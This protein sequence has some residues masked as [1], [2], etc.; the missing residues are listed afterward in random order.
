MLEQKEDPNEV[1]YQLITEDLQLEAF[2][3]IE[4]ELT[5]FVMIE[6]KQRLSGFIQ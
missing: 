6:V 1:M 5:E 2:E 3:L 4:R